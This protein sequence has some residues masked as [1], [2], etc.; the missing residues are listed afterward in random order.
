[1]ARKFENLRN[2]KRNGAQFAYLLNSLYD[3][4]TGEGYPTDADA[5]RAVWARF[6]EEFNYEY[7][8]RRY[9]NLS[10]RMGEWF[11]GLP[12]GVG[13]AY[14]SGD[15]E[16]VGRSWGYCQTEAKA[17]KF[18]ADWFGVLGWRFVQMAQALGL[19]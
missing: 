1:M 13:I 8:R 12:S 18:C 15:I 9:P 3:P 6:C 16:Q 14:A 4:E 10:Q 5:V 11:A 7:N 19:C 17:A 2:D